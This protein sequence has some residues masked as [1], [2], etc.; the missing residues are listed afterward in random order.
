MIGM[1]A[2]LIRVRAQPGACLHMQ[3]FY[4]VFVTTR[5]VSGEW[6]PHSKLLSVSRVAK[7]STLSVLYYLQANLI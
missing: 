5:D 1:S 6:Q 7:N 4:W 3:V 2:V